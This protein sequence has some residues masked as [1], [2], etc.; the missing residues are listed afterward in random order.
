MEVLKKE[1][2]NIG[3]DLLKIISMI[4][5]VLLH[6]LNFG[7]ILYNT[8]NLSINY[9]IAWL[10][11]I[12]AY[13]SVNCYA[14]I[15]GYVNINTKIKYQNIIKLW[16]R[17][18]FYTTIITLIFYIINPNT[19][20][21]LNLLKVFFPVLF[22]TYWYFTAYFCMFFFIPYLN[23]LINNLNKQLAIKLFI[24]ITILFSV[25][26]T[27]TPNDIFNINK[28]YSVIWLMILYLIGG[29][30]KKYNL[31]KKW[32]TK[33]ILIGI[34]SCILITWL[35]KYITEIT[36]L[37]ISNKI[38]ESTYF[39]EYNSITILFE[40]IF[41]LV[42][43]SRI[44][45]LNGA[46]YIKYISSLSFSIYLIHMHPLIIEYL[47]KNKFIGYIQLPFY[48]FIL[49]ILSSTI[50]ICV[51][52]IFIDMIRNKLF[53]KIKINQFSDYI[54]NKI[55]YIIKLYE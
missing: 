6:I 30:I 11:E 2:R 35:S 42:I 19:I 31:F 45:I 54:V 29:I 17:V 32:S 1:D 23:I 36:N 16:L 34:I 14:L 24:I 49:A 7:G 13:C 53:E 28:G 22:K 47:I 8:R 40:S 9:E 21:N 12:I 52:C 25:L 20:S 15:S 39:I 10:L 55:N 48:T 5:V 27:I 26:T 51:L 4:M 43:F 41:L 37:R 3:I 46:K 18:I 33:K 50:F 44:K 38:I